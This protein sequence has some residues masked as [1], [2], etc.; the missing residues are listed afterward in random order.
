MIKSIKMEVTLLCSIAKVSTSG[1]YKWLQSSK[2]EEKDH[3]DYFLIKAEFDKGKAKYGARTICMNLEKP[4]NLKKIRRIMTKYGLVTKIRRVNPYK[5]IMKKTM[6]HATAPNVLNR[7]FDQKE[8]YK[9]LGTDI[10]YLPYHYRFAYLSVVKDIVTGEILSWE[11]SQHLEMG[12]VMNTMEKLK[13]D[14]G[15][16][17]EG[18]LLHSDQGF[19]YTNPLYIQKLKEL[20]MIQSMSRKGKCIDNAPTESFFGHMK[21]DIEMKGCKTYEE[22]KLIISEYMR[23]YNYERRQWDRKKMTPVE[24]RN[25]LLNTRG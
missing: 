16:D 5:M 13:R 19:H 1:Y 21:D 12:I 11:L 20:K 17:F 2:K 24:Y 15:K 8:P 10:S 22:V 3:G 7:E 4:M 6:E 25:H 9:I 23:Y 18:V 14:D